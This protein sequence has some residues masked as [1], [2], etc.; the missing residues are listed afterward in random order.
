MENAI[1]T[2]VT[3]AT[4]KI[5]DDAAENSLVAS[6]VGRSSLLSFFGAMPQR[7]LG[8]E[9]NEIA[10]TTAASTNTKAEGS[11]FGMMPQELPWQCYFP[12]S[13]LIVDT[14]CHRLVLELESANTPFGYFMIDNSIMIY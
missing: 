14:T 1:A 13:S 11:L 6:T 7:S 3:T 2:A 12:F 9:E 10:I 4:T 8:G 5:E